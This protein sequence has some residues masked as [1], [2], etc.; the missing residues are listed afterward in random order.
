MHYNLSTQTCMTAH[1]KHREKVKTGPGSGCLC[2]PESHGNHLW[3]SGGCEQQNCPVRH[4]W[5][6][7]ANTQLCVCLEPEMQWEQ[8]WWSH[9]RVAGCVCCQHND[10][11]LLNREGITEK[12]WHHQHALCSVTR[13]SQQRA[14]SPKAGST[15]KHPGFEIHAWGCWLN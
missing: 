7:Q 4:K 12:L 13:W 9:R 10:D 14:S 8:V 11:S 3:F 15:Y 5:F 1:R 2:G 6:P